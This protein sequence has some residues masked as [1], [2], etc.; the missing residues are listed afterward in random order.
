MQEKTQATYHLLNSID[1]IGLGE[2]L[3]NP[4]VKVLMLHLV[5][6]LFPDHRLP[7]VHPVRQQV[8]SDLRLSLQLQV[9]LGDQDRVN[10]LVHTG[11]PRKK[12]T[13]TPGTIIFT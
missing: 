6:L 5:L 13:V 2:Q 8:L 9:F 7:E 10:Y 4:V 1:G 3:S 12:F 11:C